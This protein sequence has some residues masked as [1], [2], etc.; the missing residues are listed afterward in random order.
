VIEVDYGYT[1]EHCRSF[2]QLA[3]ALAVRLQFDAD[4]CRN[5]EFAALL[6]DIGKLAIPKEIINKPGKL[7]SEEWTVIQTHT[8]EGQQILDRIGGFMHTVGLIVRAHHERWDGGG[9]PDGLATASDTIPVEAR[10]ISCCDWWNAMR[11][12]RSYRNAMSHEVAH[13]ELLANAGSQFDPHIVEVFLALV[14]EL[15]ATEP[16]TSARVT[17]APSTVQP[18]VLTGSGVNPRVGVEQTSS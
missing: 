9:Y 2:V 11:T 4:H 13:V 12:D 1:G 15:R 14:D 5:V 3:I 18:Q 10:I 16:P 7:T 8:R 6:H 17:A